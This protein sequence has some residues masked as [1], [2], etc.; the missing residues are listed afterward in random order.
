M[1]NG[2]MSV[3]GNGGGKKININTGSRIKGRKVDKRN[4]ANKILDK[5]K[6]MR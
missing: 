4:V 6:K 1:T 2:K 5:Q 3:E